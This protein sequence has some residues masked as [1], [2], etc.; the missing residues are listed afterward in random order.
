MYNILSV[1]AYRQLVPVGYSPIMVNDES[2]GQV[3]KLWDLVLTDIKK[4]VE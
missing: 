1:D 2:K 3:R 4:P